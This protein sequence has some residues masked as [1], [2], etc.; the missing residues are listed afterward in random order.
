MSLLDL[1]F[2]K[3][4]AAFTRGKL[5]GAH[6]NPLPNSLRQTS[7]AELVD[8]E[9]AEII[10]HGLAA[11]LRL[12]KFKQTMGLARVQ[13]IIGI[14]KGLAPKSLLDIGSGRGTFLWPLLDAFPELAIT[15]IDKDEKR[16]ADILAVRA[17]GFN[18]LDARNLNV[19][20]LDFTD[21][22][23]DVVT[24]L[25]VLEHIPAAQQALNE[26]ARVA[27]RSLLVS[28]PS[29]PDDNPEHIHLFD[30]KRLTA[31]L[32]AAGTVNARF[33]YV[34]NHLIVVA[35]IGVGNE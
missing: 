23:F 1:Y 28:V 35:K 33:E 2:G 4:A 11:G 30:Q 20:S 15:A 26:V 7:L 8:E 13:R 5:A 31:M 6:D 9:L 22:N 25:E 3:I 17:G 24:M 12:H 16:V 10:Q 32:A 34:L 14:L 18:N 21:D 29:K 27:S 19:T